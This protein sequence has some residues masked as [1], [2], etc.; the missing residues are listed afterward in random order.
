MSHDCT[1]SPTLQHMYHPVFLSLVQVLMQ[2]G[3]YPL[4]EEYH[5]WNAG[6]YKKQ[7]ATEKVFF[8]INKKA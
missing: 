1:K 4:E 8:L 3:R 2:K 6:N 5:N 7:F